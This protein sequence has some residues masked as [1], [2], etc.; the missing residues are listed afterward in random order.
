MTI[1]KETFNSKTKSSVWKFVENSMN[2]YKKCFNPSDLKDARTAYE[3][4]KEMGGTK[5]IERLE[6]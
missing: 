1:T 2:S 6:A 3:V 5:T 4:Y